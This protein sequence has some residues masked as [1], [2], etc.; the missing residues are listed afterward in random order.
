MISAHPEQFEQVG[1][2][3]CAHCKRSNLSWQLKCVWCGADLIAHTGPLQN[4]Y[5]ELALLDDV[6][7]P[8]DKDHTME[9]AT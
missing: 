7:E 6:E 8:D 9:N 2:I 1:I 3:D 5:N 4:I